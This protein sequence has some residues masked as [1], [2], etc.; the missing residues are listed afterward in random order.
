MAASSSRSI[1]RCRRGALDKLVKHPDRAPPADRTDRPELPHA[2]IVG[3]TWKVID[4]YYGAISQLTAQRSDFAAAAQ[5]GP[6]AL[7]A[8]MNAKPD[9]LLK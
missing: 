4:V 6:A 3:G 2:A 1:R 5:K 8:S 7:T 9:Q